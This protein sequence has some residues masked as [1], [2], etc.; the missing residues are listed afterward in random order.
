MKKKRNRR[1][2]KEPTANFKRE[3]Y[4]YC[5]KI[6]GQAPEQNRGNRRKNQ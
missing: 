2:K 1:N 5:G 3:E 6:N 4:N